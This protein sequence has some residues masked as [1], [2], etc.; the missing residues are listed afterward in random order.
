MSYFAHGLL[1]A[2]S[3][4]GK[5]KERRRDVIVVTMVGFIMAQLKLV[6]QLTYPGS[7]ESWF[8]PERQKS[9]LIL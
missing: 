4:A 3:D 7:A 5:G 9:K 6:S 8:S 1:G 2:A